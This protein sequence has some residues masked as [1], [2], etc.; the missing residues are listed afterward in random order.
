LLELIVDKEDTSIGFSE[1][2][3]DLLVE[4]V[5][6]HETL[7]DGPTFMDLLYSPVIVDSLVSSLLNPHPSNPYVLSLI[8]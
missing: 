3:R 6:K 2:A 8:K 1:H 5:E 7:L 4:L